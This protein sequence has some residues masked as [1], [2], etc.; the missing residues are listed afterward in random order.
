[1][2]ATVVKNISGQNAIILADKIITELYA[3]RH[4]H[5][6]FPENIDSLKTNRSDINR[7]KKT[8]TYILDKQ[9]STFSIY[10]WSDAGISMSIIQV[11]VP[12]T[13]KSNASSQQGF[14]KIRATEYRLKD[15][16]NSNRLLYLGRSK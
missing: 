1:L 3:Y 7:F 13:N 12:G 16:G 10:A 9:D 2:T 8:Q 11:T 15:I 5:G 6:Q 14:C 4:D